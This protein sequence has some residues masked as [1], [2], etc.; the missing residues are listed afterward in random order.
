MEEAPAEEE[1]LVVAG[2]SPVTSE[3]E[4][5]SSTVKKM[6]QVTCIRILELCIYHIGGT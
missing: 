2:E 6:E 5:G 1:P 4:K 3:T